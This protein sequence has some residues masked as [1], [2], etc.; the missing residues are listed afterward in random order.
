MT[1]P[2][3]E[4]T[5]F[6]RVMRNNLY[7]DACRYV[8]ADEH[9]SPATMASYMADCIKRHTYNAG[10]PRYWSFASFA[11]KR[12]D[13]SA[14]SCNTA[15]VLEYGKSRMADVLA[16]LADMNLAH[17]I[18]ET[19]TTTENR[20]AVVI[21]TTEPILNEARSN[22]YARAASVLID[23]IG[24][25]GVVEGS[26]APTF[27]IRPIGNAAVQDFPGNVLD[28]AAFIA[29]T[30]TRKAKARDYMSVKEEVDPQAALFVWASK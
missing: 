6:D 12:H 4:L 17:W 5:R 18:V 9:G 25:G 15:I 29:D 21:P 7:I 23:Q 11:F 1:Y 20:F 19:E 10:E 2:I 27:L 3:L 26:I 24:V 22:R 14:I 16:E 13:K 30:A 8:M 28:V